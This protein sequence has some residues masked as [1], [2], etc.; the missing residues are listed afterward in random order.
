M[1]DNS[2]R[3]RYETARA[4]WNRAIGHLDPATIEKVRDFL[5]IVANDGANRVF[6]ERNARELITRL[7]AILGKP[8]SQTP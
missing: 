5:L 1:I 3:A 6:L 8:A 4:D 7:D 2:Y